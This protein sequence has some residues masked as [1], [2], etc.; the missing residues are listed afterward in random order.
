MEMGRRRVEKKKRFSVQVRFLPGP[1]SSSDGISLEDGL[2][3]AANTSPRQLMTAPVNH[4]SFV[5]CG[6]G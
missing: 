2:S 1:F 4:N 5:L 6:A 3:D